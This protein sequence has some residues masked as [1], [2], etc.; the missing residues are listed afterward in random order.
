MQ[1]REYVRQAMFEINALA[2][3]EDMENADG[4]LGVNMCNELIDQWAGMQATVYETVRTEH[5]L[6]ANQ[7]SYTI[8]DD[9]IADWP[10]WRPTN[11]PDRAGFVDVLSNVTNPVERKI[12]VFTEQ[13]WGGIGQ[14]DLI[15][16]EVFGVWYQKSFPLGV[17][18]VYPRCSLA[19]KIA[20]YVPTPI[21]STVTL[22]TELALPPSGR[23]AFRL[24]LAMAMAPAFEVPVS[25]LLVR[26]TATALDIYMKSFYKST[27]L[28]I[29]SRLKAT[30]RRG[31]NIITNE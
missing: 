30:G 20:L 22:D 13:E 31:Y 7:R 29:P 5:T 8:G 21:S 27:K 4:V 12:R 10:G 18:W 28:Q 1:I 16:T 26:T 25:E 17:V 14:K 23:R 2:P 6:V 15:N 19:Q 24:S 11:D 9:A 3:G